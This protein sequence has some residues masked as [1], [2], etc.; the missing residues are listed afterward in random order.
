MLDQKISN[1]CTFGSRSLLDQQQT[2]P[3]ITGF[4]ICVHMSSSIHSS[5]TK[6]HS[7][8][9]LSSL[10]GIVFFFIVWKSRTNCLVKCN[11]N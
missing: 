8:I 11:P 3:N 6:N 4:M 2:V 10:E 1:L 5:T 7:C 9:S